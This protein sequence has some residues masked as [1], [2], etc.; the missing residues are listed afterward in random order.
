MKL[1][2]E[3]VNLHIELFKFKDI[4]I[5]NNFLH[6]QLLK[7]PLKI[8][9]SEFVSLLTN[10][11]EDTQ[12]KILPLLNQLAKVSSTAEILSNKTFNPTLSISTFYSQLK[13]KAL[14]LALIIDLFNA[15][16][17]VPLKAEYQ[18]LV[19]S[20]FSYDEATQFVNVFYS[21]VHPVPDVD[22]IFSLLDEFYAHTVK[23][24]KLR[25]EYA[26][27]TGIFFSA[28]DP[29]PYH[30][31]KQHIGLT[32]MQFELGKIEESLRVEKGKMF[33][34]II[35]DNFRTV[36]S[37]NALSKSVGSFNSDLPNSLSQLIKRFLNMEMIFL[38]IR[39]LT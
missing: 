1:L 14:A 7:V 4:P 23:M 12:S 26:K 2:R 34:E 38:E 30:L 20:G 32:Q 21:K 33:R 16:V 19:K 3:V 24:D 36:A 31:Y 5:L 29:L 35:P 11:E 39:D 25:A 17:P 27:P 37:F 10:L 8:A 9:Y 18:L 22:S 15:E 6:E 28:S 13:S